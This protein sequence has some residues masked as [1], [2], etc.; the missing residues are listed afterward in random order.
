M[1]SNPP[2]F[3]SSC[4]DDPKG[5]RLRI[6]DRVIGATGGPNLP[7]YS[8]PV[9]MAE[10]Y[11]ELKLVSP[12]NDLEKTE[13]CLEGVRQAEC[14]VAVITSRHGSKVEVPGIG[15]VHTSFFE[16]ELFEAALLG[17]PAFVFL[18]DGHT[19]D[20]SLA[21]LL[22]LL[23]PAF[24]GM[25]LRPMSEDA[26]ARSI[27]RL[28]HKHRRPR[29]LRLL[30]TPPRLGLMVDKLFCLRHRSY[31]VKTELPP[32]RFLESKFDTAVPPPD[33]AL[34]ESLLT[35]AAATATY[36]AR[37]TLI[38]FAIRMLM[39]APY[40]DPAHVAFLSKWTR[41]FSAWNSSAAWYGLHGP[42]LMSCLAALG[43]LA[44][45]AVTSSVKAGPAAA[46]P[47]GAFASEYYSTGKLASRGTSIFDLALRHV[48]AAIDVASEDGANE[49]AIRGSIHLRMGRK[50]A[51][52][53]DYR[54]VA[55]LRREKGRASYGDALSE[56]GYAQFLAGERTQGL[57]RMEEGLLILKSAPPSGFQVRAMR[58]LAV[59]YARCMK[60][61]S[62]LDLAVQAHDLAAALGAH[63]QIRTLERLAKHIDRARIRLH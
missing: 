25:N 9:W 53:V 49:I 47:H 7:P 21:N 8:R 28:V 43:S 18:L 2:V 15:I 54:R 12:L 29:W 42:A 39:G 41:S 10:D 35:R 22:K 52:L 37:L 1:A 36:Q 34:V 51:A 23:A 55:E 13:L 24:P 45:I 31:D 46:I 48:E 20:D 6:R 3:L 61:G 17:K 33:P 26:I 27:H 63:D 16:A 32:W 4:F 62:A 14:F 40:N 30:M 19:P 38:W 5:S 44:E 58:K 60:F 59:G 56:L 50:D 57:T 11:P